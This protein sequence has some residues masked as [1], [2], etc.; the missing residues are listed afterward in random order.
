MKWT[1]RFWSSLEIDDYELLVNPHNCKVVLP[2][3]TT[4]DE[5]YLMYEHAYKHASQGPHEWARFVGLF[6][7]ES[8]RPERSLCLKP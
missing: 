3:G 1:I 8:S 7:N 5:A 4:V 2:E 6:R